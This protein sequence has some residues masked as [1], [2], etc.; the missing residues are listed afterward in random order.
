MSFNRCRKK[1]P[2]P[3]VVSCESIYNLLPKPC[4]VVKK[5]PM[6]KSKYSA[7]IRQQAKNQKKFAQRTFGRPSQPVILPIKY[8]KK[9]SKVPK[10]M[11][12]FKEMDT[13]GKDGKTSPCKV[14][15]ELTKK[16]I[17]Q[18]CKPGKKR[19][20]TRDLIK[21]NEPKEIITKDEA[22]LC[23]GDASKQEGEEKDKELEKKKSKKSKKKRNFI[24]E[25]A[26]AVIGAK[27]NRPPSKMVVFTRKG[28]K[29]DFEGAGLDM[30]FCRSEAFAK[31]PEYLE[32]RR[33]QVEAA[34]D[35]YD[36]KI[37]ER[38]RAGAMR[39]LSCE[40]R[41]EMLAC[42]QENREKLYQLYNRLPI[43]IHTSLM[44]NKKIYLEKHLS[45]LEHDIRLISAHPEI[46]L[47]NW[48]MF[49]S[50]VCQSPQVWVDMRLKVV[51]Y[52]RV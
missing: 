10:V 3:C 15:E 50:S 4:Q 32:K 16:E 12:Q 26:R 38:M 28:D 19:E 18:G 46:Y 2:K 20:T 27:P 14:L 34:R 8:V 7:L 51:R 40:E 31:K 11:H 45:Q 36:E 37:S 52:M 23:Q 5:P 49:Y 17:K 25:N 41:E 43:L 9:V 24:S 48:C 6:Y 33:Q 42:L 13:G 35:E 30:K 39:K 44:K 47:A 22:P 29:L 21:K 1:P